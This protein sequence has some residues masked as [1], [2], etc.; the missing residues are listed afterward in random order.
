MQKI[1][2]FIL[3]WLNNPLPVEYTYKQKFLNSFIFGLFIFIF[4]LIFQ[5]FGIDDVE[6]C[7]IEA[8]AG[9]GLITFL[10]VLVNNVLM[11]L[12]FKNYFT[13]KNWNVGKSLLFSFW[14][15]LNIATLNWIYNE[16]LG[17]TVI[18][19]HD[20]ISFVS[21]TIAVGF[22][23]MF[24]F[25]VLEEK[26]RHKKE[27]SYKTIKVSEQTKSIKKIKI[28]GENENEQ[29]NIELN[30]LLCVKSEGNY[31]VV[32]Y[33]NED[34][35]LKKTFRTSLKK[36]EEQFTDFPE[37]IRCHKSYL[38]NLSHINEISGNV[39]NYQFH[40][41]HLDFAIPVSRNFP[42]EIIQNLRKAD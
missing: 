30:Q 13:N 1:I 17:H 36:Q 40:V 39:R 27:L 19:H 18:A 26:M 14:I 9:Y 3:N 28:V 41:Q 16:F 20:F 15:I 7:K 5:P 37:I 8:I 25:T 21:I 6:C 33:I 32:Y 29:L 11:P 23:P 22:F 10:V 42:K 35:T 31:S 12:L 38:V 2:S 24:V 34:K 4:L